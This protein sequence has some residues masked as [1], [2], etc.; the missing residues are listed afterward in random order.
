MNASLKNASTSLDAGWLRAPA[1]GAWRVLER[2][3]D[4]LVGAAANPLRQLDALGF[5]FFWWLAA[6]GLYLFAALD[7][8][9]TAAFESI[10]GLSRLPWYQGG[11]LRS[12]HRYAAQLAAGPPLALALS[13]RLLLASPEATLDAQ[14]REEFTHIKS[15]FA[16]ADVREALAAFKEK[17]APTFEGR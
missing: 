6:S 13:K 4:G 17:R 3:L 7:S 1:L 8:S 16:S 11:W 9:A 5:L 14:L 15:C 10:A 12:V 2:S